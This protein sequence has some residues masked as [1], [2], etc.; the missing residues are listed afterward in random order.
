MTNEDKLMAQNII[1]TC[2]F[3]H[4]SVYSNF[5]LLLEVELNLK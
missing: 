5:V 2:P 3:E 4:L 1:E